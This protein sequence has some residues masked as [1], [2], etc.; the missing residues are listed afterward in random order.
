MT[1]WSEFPS[2]W[3]KKENF[4]LEL[5]CGP[6]QPYLYYPSDLMILLYVYTVGLSVSKAPFLSDNNIIETGG[7]HLVKGEKISSIL[8]KR[9]G[10]Q[11]QV[12]FH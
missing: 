4:Y 5:K 3:E 7:T 10:C 11:W 2:S 12:T 9:E 1:K 6:A 8:Q